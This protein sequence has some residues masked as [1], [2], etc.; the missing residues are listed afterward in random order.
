VFDKTF[1]YVNKRFVNPETVKEV[2]K[3]LLRFADKLEPFEMAQ[4]ANLMPESSEEAKILIPSLTYRID[5]DDLQALLSEM[6][7]LCSSSSML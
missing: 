6:R 2:R 5:D 1:H 7:I 4:L 3:L